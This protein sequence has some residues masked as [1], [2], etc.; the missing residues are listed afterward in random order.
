MPKSSEKQVKQ[1]SEKILAELLK[2]ANKSINEIA[3][4]CGFSRQ[5]VW[6]V[7][8]DLEKNNAIWGYVAI[9]NPEKLNKKRYFMLMKRSNKPIPKNLINEITNREMPETAKKIGIEFIDSIML[10]GEY[11]YMISFYAYNMRDA[12]NMVELYNRLYPDLVSEV[13]LHE[14]LFA[15]QKNGLNN[16]EVKKFEDFFRI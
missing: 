4:A 13:S 12:K 14:E 1:D 9:I 11:D 7:I 10:N 5:K 15:V 6:R 16:P 2:N 8:K 3:E